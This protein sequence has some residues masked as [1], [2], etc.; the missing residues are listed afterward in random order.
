MGNDKYD[1]E[2]FM[3]SDEEKEKARDARKKAVYGS[4]EEEV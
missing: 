2:A 3:G 4:E 1:I